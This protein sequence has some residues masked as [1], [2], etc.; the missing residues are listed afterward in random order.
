MSINNPFDSADA[1]ENSC[2]VS[3]KPGKRNSHVMAHSGLPLKW[4]L[5][6]HV[7]EQVRVLIL[8]SAFPCILGRSALTNNAYRFGFYRDATSSASI[9]GLGRDLWWFATEQPKIFAD[10]FSTFIAS[11]Q[12]PVVKDE[13]HFETLLWNVLQSLNHLDAAHHKWD[14]TTSSDPESNKFSFSFAGRSFFLVGLNYHSPRYSRK[15][16]YPTLVFNSHNQFERLRA[17]GKFDTVQKTIR[18][19]DIQLQGDINPNLHNYGDASEAKQYSGRFVT[20]DW[21]CPFKAKRNDE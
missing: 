17:E 19:R 16:A 2:Y 10:Q 15:F 21:K 6:N 8:N 7:H 18:K 11:F 1:T 12:E 5:A 20:D 4:A 14:P 9:Q 13:L 3:Y